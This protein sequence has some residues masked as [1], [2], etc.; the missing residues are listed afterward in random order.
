M[1]CKAQTHLQ[2]CKFIDF[3]GVLI[4]KVHL[5]QFT[6]GISFLS[7]CRKLRLHSSQLVLPTGK[8][9]RQR[10][11][12]RRPCTHPSRQRTRETGP[13]LHG[14]MRDG[15]KEEQEKERNNQRN[16]TTATKEGSRGGS[17]VV[18]AT[19]DSQVVSVNHGGIGQS[20]D[21]RGLSGSYTQSYRV[22]LEG[23]SYLMSSFAAYFDDFFLV[24]ASLVG[25]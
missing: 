7:V 23:M 18:M 15:N 13:G 9:S 5:E 1:Q 19:R 16:G 2:S 4:T 17:G 3:K 22:R 25:E 11:I 21:V 24:V 10:E 12:Q 6:N 8:R 14:G 20:R